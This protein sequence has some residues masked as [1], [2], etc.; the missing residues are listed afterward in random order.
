MSGSHEVSIESA[1]SDYKTRYGKGRLK[2]WFYRIREFF[3]KDSDA[4]IQYKP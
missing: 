3:S 4:N 2:R 1:T